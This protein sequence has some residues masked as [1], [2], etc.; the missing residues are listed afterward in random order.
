MRVNGSLYTVLH[1]WLETTAMPSHSGSNFTAVHYFAAND[2]VEIW[3]D[4][5]NTHRTTSSTPHYW[6]GGLLYAVA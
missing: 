1:R 2:Y 4:G 6:S 3:N 5:G